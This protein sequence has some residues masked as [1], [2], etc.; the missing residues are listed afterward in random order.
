MVVLFP[1]ERLMPKMTAYSDRRKTTPSQISLWRWL[2]DHGPHPQI[3]YYVDE[4]GI[5]VDLAYPDQRL[6]IEVDGPCHREWK[7]KED[8][9]FRDLSLHKAGWGGVRVTNDEINA[10]LESVGYRILAELRNRKKALLRTPRSSE[11]F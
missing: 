11:P 2:R 3:E 8:D 1:E 6:A 7:R 9:E 5:H 4:C 10:D